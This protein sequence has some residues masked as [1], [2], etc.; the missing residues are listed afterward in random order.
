MF[1]RFTEKARRVIFFAR[2]EASSL[3]TPYIDT[4]HLLLG[5]LRE[6][7]ALIRHALPNVDY[8]SARQ[9]IA[10]RVGTKQKNIP[11][12]VDL[13]LA[14]DAESALKY[15]MEEADRLNSKYI[16]T[17]HLLL[18]LVHNSEFASAKFLSRFGGNLD[19]LRKRVEALPLSTGLSELESPSART[20]FPAYVRRFAQAPG[21]PPPDIIEIH[22]RK[23][24]T[25]II[26]QA[27]TRLTSDAWLWER[28]LWQPRDV[29]YEKNGKRLSF[30]LTLA[31]DTEKFLLVKN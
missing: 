4:N 12:S 9:D 28:K 11:T 26:R 31:Q 21:S 30:D 14:E 8:E 5:M 6:D 2:Y 20:V 18:A 1:E 22:G 27:A 24:F 17:G 15:A 3:G 23:W 19:S 10:E 13:P 16:D 25:E 29:V 7:K